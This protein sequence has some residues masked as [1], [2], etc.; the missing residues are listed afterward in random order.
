MQIKDVADLFIMAINKVEFYWNFYVVMLI[1]LI[2]WLIS[3]K[4]PLSTSLKFLITA[5]YALFAMMNIVGLYS[6]YTLAEALRNDLLEMEGAKALV[7]VYGVF[8]S[9]SFIQQRTAVFWIHIIVGLAV[10]SAV[11]LGRFERVPA[12]DK[13]H[14]DRERSRN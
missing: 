6:S 11:W 14:S 1:A 4:N 5:G 13:P 8:Q 9:L 2:G 3:T 12:N 10:L 7:H